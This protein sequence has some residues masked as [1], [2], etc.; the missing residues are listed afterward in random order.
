M[1]ASNSVSQVVRIEEGLAPKKPARRQLS[2]LV[3]ALQSSH[4]STNPAQRVA[5]HSVVI[6]AIGAEHLRARKL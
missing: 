6:S 2:G 5:L 3:L 4:P 1:L